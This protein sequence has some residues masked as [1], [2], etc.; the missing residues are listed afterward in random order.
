MEMQFG[1]K[2]EFEGNVYFLNKGPEKRKIAL[3]VSLGFVAILFFV[4]LVFF[5]KR[6][7]FC[8]F[9]RSSS[10]VFVGANFVGTKNDIRNAVGMS[11]LYDKD[12][13]AEGSEE[14]LLRPPNVDMSS[15]LD[16]QP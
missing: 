9:K 6:A 16:V 5:L 15:M 4:I 2:P 7:K 14:K 11:Q 12:P 13:T 1:I 10:L 3:F 8:C